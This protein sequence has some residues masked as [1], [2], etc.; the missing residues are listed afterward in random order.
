MIIVQ[1][2]ITQD[3]Q[4]AVVENDI[5]KDTLEVSHTRTRVERLKKMLAELDEEIMQK[6]EIISRSLAEMTKR[7]AMIERKQGIID[8]YNKK[9]ELM[10]SQAG[11]GILDER[12]SA[13]CH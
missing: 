11:V 3:Q 4:I 6:N 13:C 1:F 8:Q 7:N 10:I 12:T 2:C 5:S 9:L